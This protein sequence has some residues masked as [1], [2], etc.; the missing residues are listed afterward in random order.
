MRSKENFTKGIT[1]VALVVTLVILLILTSITI[2]TLTGG[3]GLIAQ[4]KEQ[5]NE[6]L[7]KETQDNKEIS[8][9]ENK[10]KTDNVITIPNATNNN[11][12]FEYSPLTWTKDSVTV[13]IS[14]TTNYSLQYSV[15]NTTSWQSYEGPLTETSNVDIYARLTDNNEHY[16]LPVKG[17]VSNIDREG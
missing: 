7:N 4:S 3:N 2:K 16:G 1:L 6:I 17:R 14:R 11:V 13:T 5:K 9:M 8:D 12:R 15:G 10:L